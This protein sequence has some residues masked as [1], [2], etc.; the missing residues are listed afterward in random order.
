VRRLL[1]IVS[2]VVAC[3]EDAAAPFEPAEVHLVIDRDADTHATGRL[4][5]WN[6]GRGTLYARAGDPVHGDW[7]TP[8]RERAFAMLASIRGQQPP[9]VRFSGLQIDGALGGDG[10]HFWDFARS[11]REPGPDDNMAPYQSMAIVEEI[12]AEPRVTVNFGSGTAEEAARYVDHLVGAGDSPEVQARRDA[13]F[14]EPWP[15]HAYEIGNETYGFW[16]TGYSATG[17]YAYANPDASHGGDPA[18]HGRPAMRPADYAARALAYVDAIA[19]VD[20]QARFS[21]P[22][23]QASMDAWGGL[24]SALSALEPLLVHASVEA[25]VVHHY[26][27]DDLAPLGW[28]GK[29][30]PELA[31]AGSVALEPG[32]VDLRRRLD[33]L[34]RATPLRIAITEYH[35]AGAFTLGAFDERADTHLVGLGVADVLLSFAHL[36]IDEALQ[37]M[38]IAFGGSAGG[39]MLFEPWYNPLRETAA[40]DV[41]A[42]PSFV[43][44]ALVA[45]HLRETTV[46]PVVEAMPT[47][48]YDA[49]AAPLEYAI[50]RAVAFADDESTTLVL[51]NRDLERD[52]SVTFDVTPHAWP[53][54]SARVYAPPS[55]DQPLGDTAIEI[56]EIDVEQQGG[57]L[58]VVLPRHSLAA[59]TLSR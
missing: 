26:Q 34:P 33:A 36:G 28:F 22:L 40:G 3:A 25:V 7:R 17:E 4:V 6:V 59:I 57:R 32:Y 48:V 1:V 44:T 16:N 46:R 55:W 45:E 43:A 56:A 13:G 38:A 5:G 24:D 30:A 41:I 14:V 54:A 31:V 10:Y 52:R 37:H 11:D 27:V 8:Q 58:R 2:L 18:W 39:E 23:T 29:A 21:I 19:A 15:V 50:V 35:V 47:S 49:E 20:P 12:D 53:V 42:A 9:I 51:L